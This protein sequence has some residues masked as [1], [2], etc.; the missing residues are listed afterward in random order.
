MV[1]IITAALPYINNVPHLGHIIGSHLPADVYNRFCKLNGEETCFV[2]GS[3]VHGTPSLLLAKELNIEP[4]ILTDKLHEVHKKIYKY[5]NISYDNYSKTSSPHHLEN[6]QNFFKE[7]EKNGYIEEQEVLMKYCLHDKIFLPDRF[8]EGVCPNCGYESANG[9]Q[10]EKCGILIEPSTLISAKCKLCGTS[11]IEKN[12]IHLNFK[13]DKLSNEIRAWVEEKKNVFNSITNSEAQNW[14]SKELHSRS[15]TRS[16]KWGIPVPNEK[17]LDKVFYVWFEAPIAYISFVEEINSEKLW[18]KKDT[19]IYHFLGKDNIPFHTIFWP[20]LLLGNKKYTLPYN[21]VGYNYLNYE[22]EK[23]S[24]SKGIGVFCINFLDSDVNIDSIRA[25]LISILPEKKDSNFNFI[26][27]KNFHN[28]EIIGKM[29]NLINRNFSMVWKNLGGKV[30]VSFN[31][32]SET[33]QD[34]ILKVKEICLEIKKCYEKCL[35]REALSLIVELAITGNVY[36][37]QEKPWAVCK[38]GNTEKLKE[39]LG[40]TTYICENL[41]YW[42]YPIMPDTVEKLYLMQLNKKREALKKD[43]LHVISYEIKEPFPVF[44]RIDEDI[45]KKFQKQ[46]TREFSLSELVKL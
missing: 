13:L 30:D 14:L 10:C 11:P 44:E 46:L 25:Y 23:F 29:F 36:F 24:K 8:V 3:D 17:Y 16:M 19:K 43:E 6:T 22:N 27:Y 12:D 5:F 42:L 40:V 4:K 37:D 2:G 7:I 9:D 32:N 28:S 18:E 20:G 15:I 38:E 41:L 35:F 39:I 33:A 45:L 21:V 1:K 26:E 34:T 31:S